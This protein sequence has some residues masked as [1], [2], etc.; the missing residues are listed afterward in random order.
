LGSIILGTSSHP[1]KP[2]VT[3]LWHKKVESLGESL[4]PQIAV[5]HAIINNPGQLSYSSPDPSRRTVY[6]RLP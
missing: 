6:P 3:I 1:G 4:H 2:A 5:T